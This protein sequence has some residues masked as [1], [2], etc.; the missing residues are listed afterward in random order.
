MLVSLRQQRFLTS[1]RLLLLVAAITLL[2][3]LQYYFGRALDTHVGESMVFIPML[4]AKLSDGALVIGPSTLLASS[5]TDP[6]SGRPQWVE[7]VAPSAGESDSP[8]TSIQCL[9]W[10]RNRSCAFDQIYYDSQL[11]NFVIALPDGELGNIKKAPYDG[12]ALAF[13]SATD[14]DRHLDTGI[15]VTEDSLRELMK[16]FPTAAAMAGTASDSDK[17][18]YDDHP[19]TVLSVEDSILR[20]P[21]YMGEEIADES[22]DDPRG[23]GVELSL[24]DVTTG[25]RVTYPGRGNRCEHLEIVDL[26]NSVRPAQTLVDAETLELSPPWKCPRCE[27][28][29]NCCS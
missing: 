19:F 5:L 6:N 27:Q 2:V 7:Y 24:M 8:W 16:E 1:P 29:Y 11:G 3:A 26:M 23:S 21:F 15:P 22:T 18:D 9:A 4:P 10:H 25:D 13:D 12:K 17:I 20:L 28:V 14:Y